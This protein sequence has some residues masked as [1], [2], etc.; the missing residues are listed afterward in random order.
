MPQ[1]RQHRRVLQGAPQRSGGRREIPSEPPSIGIIP[2]CR[3]PQKHH[4]HPAGFYVPGGSLPRTKSSS[5]SVPEDSTAKKAVRGATC[6]TCPSAVAHTRARSARAGGAV[7]RIT[8]TDTAHCGA[9]WDGRR[10]HQL[11]RWCIHRLV[12]SRKLCGW[13]MSAPYISAH[14]PEGGGGM[15]TTSPL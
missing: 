10:T 9:V 1:Q 4:M 13:G 8:H 7:R 14:S 2:F 5:L 15:G 12:G 11:H 6:S 3:F